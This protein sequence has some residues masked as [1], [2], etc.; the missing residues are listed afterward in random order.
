MNVRPISIDA[1]KS[2]KKSA[3]TGM[4][5]SRSGRSVF[6]RFTPG[7]FTT[8][9]YKA[10]SWSTSVCSRQNMNIGTEVPSISWLPNMKLTM[11]SGSGYASGRSS[12]AFTTVKIAVLAPMPSASVRTA[13][14]VKPGLFLSIRKP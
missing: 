6:V 14:A 12:T 2:L 13:T 8:S 5:L 10:K 7:P 9:P 1:P 3:E 11:R 4:L